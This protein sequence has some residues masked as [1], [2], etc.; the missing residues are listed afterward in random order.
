[1]S[2]KTTASEPVGYGCFKEDGTLFDAEPV[3]EN[4][5]V[6]PKGWTIAPVYT[7]PVPTAAPQPVRKLREYKGVTY[8]DGKWWLRDK[9]FHSVANLLFFRHE[10]FTDADHAAIYALREQ[11]YEPVETVED[12]LLDVVELWDS[13]TLKRYAA[14]LRA[15][16]AAEGVGYLDSVLVAIVCDVRGGMS[17]TAI[18]DKYRAALAAST[19]T[20]EGASA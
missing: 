1:M 8:R 19:R 20:G 15:A 9:R 16:V 11:P 6:I 14:R 5:R 18:L 2:E 4:F 17:T 13:D 7:H 12:V 3:R 10:S